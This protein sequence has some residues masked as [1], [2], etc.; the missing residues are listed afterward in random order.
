[1]SRNDEFHG[2]AFGSRNHTGGVPTSTEVIP[3]N[4]SEPVRRVQ[5]AALSRWSR[6]GGQTR[7]DWTDANKRSKKH[8]RPM[9]KRFKGWL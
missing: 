8:G 9:Q 5:Q 2:A 7:Q 6:E 3:T 4:V 1:M